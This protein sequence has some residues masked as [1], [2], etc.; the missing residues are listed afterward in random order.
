MGPGKGV[1]CNINCMKKIIFLLFSVALISCKKETS[2]EQETTVGEVAQKD[3]CNFNYK[4]SVEESS[5]AEF[6]AGTPNA[7]AGVFKEGLATPDTLLLP[8]E[9]ATQKKKLVFNSINPA[10]QKGY[11]DEEEVTYANLGFSKKVN[12]H[13]LNAHYYEGHDYFLIDNATAKQ[14]TINGMPN[15]SPDTKKIFSY[16][17]SPYN[18]REFLL[19]ADVEIYVLCNDGLVAL[20]KKTY[21]YIP[22][23]VKWKG[24]DTILIK[25]LS[26]SEFYKNDTE[27]IDENLRHY[28]YKKMIVK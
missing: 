28:I 21:D 11:Y 19:S 12:K 22:Y 7:L 6:A 1:G 25:A 8:V 4:V 23:A 16:Y 20:H 3:S 17:V 5:E 27:G 24:N 26:A 13:L 18:E 9:I 15:F 14:D 2:G 10:A